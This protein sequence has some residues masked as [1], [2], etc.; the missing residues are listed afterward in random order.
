MN[1]TQFV[2]HL[3]GEKSP[4]HVLGEEITVLASGDQTGTYEVFLQRGA[5]GSG[6]PPHRHAWDESFYIMRGV[7]AFGIEDQEFSA[8]AGTF[9]HLPAGTTHWFQFGVDGGE[10]L[11][12]TSR[13]A[14][15]RMFFDIDHANTQGEPDRAQIEQ[16]LAR[17][18]LDVVI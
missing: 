3:G 12:I 11:S 16:I 6:P 7:V 17:H 4:L 5:A 2:L 14:A 15:S 1:A 8:A 9:V 10:M 18:G 13:L